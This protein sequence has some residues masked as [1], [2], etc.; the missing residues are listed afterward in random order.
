MTIDEV[1][2]LAEE[3][4][5]KHIY[6]KS[7]EAFLHIQHCLSDVDCSCRSDPWTVVKNAN[8]WLEMCQFGHG[9]RFFVTTDDTGVHIGFIEAD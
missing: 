5:E 6:N 4:V 8:S 1:L 9:G 2:R 3:C 7:E